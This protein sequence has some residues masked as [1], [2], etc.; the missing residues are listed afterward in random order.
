MSIR[1]FPLV[2]H[3]RS[4]YNKYTGLIACESCLSCGFL[5]KTKVL[6]VH[7][8]SPVAVLL[9]L[10]MA[11]EVLRY[12]GQDGLSSFKIVTATVVFILGTLGNIIIIEAE[13]NLSIW[14]GCYKNLQNI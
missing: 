4:L 7:L 2:E 11:L 14:G 3:A 10:F 9:S 8:C 12:F 5:C 13:R 1:T 6:S